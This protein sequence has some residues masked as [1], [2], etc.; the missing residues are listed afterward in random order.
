[1]QFL[2]PARFPY[3][4][5]GYATVNALTQCHRRDTMVLT[6]AS[7]FVECGLLPLPGLWAG[8]SRYLLLPGLQVIKAPR[9]ELRPTV[10]KET[11]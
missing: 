4:M 6:A 2:T 9:A 5:L 8:A 11:S 1:M 7:F 10:I 3:A